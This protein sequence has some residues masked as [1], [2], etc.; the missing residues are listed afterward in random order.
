M[1]EVELEEILENIEQSMPRKKAKVGKK[2]NFCHQKDCHNKFGGACKTKSGC[3]AKRCCRCGK[4]ISTSNISKHTPKCQGRPQP[5]FSK[6][7]YQ[8]KR[9]Q[10][11]KEQRLV[12]LA[13][14]RA[15]KK[16][17][18]LRGKCS[19]LTFSSICAN[20]DLLCDVEAKLTV[21]DSEIPVKL[22][23]QSLLNPLLEDFGL[24]L[25]VYENFA[26]DVFRM[27]GKT[28][29]GQYSK[30][31]L[32][33]L[34]NFLTNYSEHL[35]DEDEDGDATAV[36]LKQ[37]LIQKTITLLEKKIVNFLKD[38][39]L[40]SI[41]PNGAFIS[42]QEELFVSRMRKREANQENVDKA[43]LLLKKWEEFVPYIRNGK[44]EEE[45][46]KMYERNR[47]AKRSQ[48]EEKTEE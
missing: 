45:Y 27:N 42:S 32:Q 15:K 6:P 33:E 14:N 8:Q 28:V 31:W 9:Y 43:K 25:H 48:E 21:Q 11:Q 10:E 36:A 7:E 18:E 5:K 34:I 17:K 19:F 4:A 44:F 13:K 29:A 12:D 26:G 30:Q 39:S 41:F 23:R 24:F 2:C 20:F 47:D 38:K 1:S 22:S 37:K 46:M 35:D 3:D 16:E 40:L